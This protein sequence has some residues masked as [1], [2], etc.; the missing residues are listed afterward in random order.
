M[1]IAKTYRWRQR[2]NTE[3][4]DGID[5]LGCSTLLLTEL[6]AHVGNKLASLI[7]HTETAIKKHSSGTLCQ[8]VELLDL[9]KRVPFLYCTVTLYLARQVCMQII[10]LAIQ[11]AD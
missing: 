3:V 9:T 2:E 11:R 5:T 7:G 6:I 8:E 4:V 10:E 1:N